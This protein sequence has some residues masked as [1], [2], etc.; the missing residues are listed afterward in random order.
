[1]GKRG[2]TMKKLICAFLLV[3]STGSISAA[4]TNWNESMLLEYRD[5]T[6]ALLGAMANYHV[7]C[8]GKRTNST[9]EALQKQ[10]V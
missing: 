9:K 1:M 4:S 8:G 6:G 5:Y 10:T 7:R 2:G 3:C